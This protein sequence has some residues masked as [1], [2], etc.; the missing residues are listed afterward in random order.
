MDAPYNPS[1][2]VRIAA[3][4]TIVAL[5]IAMLMF[6]REIIIPFTL[7]VFLTF[8]LLPI[9]NWL[10]AKKI[11]HAI[12]IL[13]SIF[14]AGIVLAGLI[15][16]FYAQIIS[17]S[18]DLPELKEQFIIKMNRI[19]EYIFHEFNIS[20]RSQE[21]W[22]MEK[23]KRTTGNSEQIIVSLFSYTGTFLANLALIPVYAFFL[24]YFKEKYKMFIIMISPSAEQK[25]VLGIMRQVSKV[26]QKYLKG[27]LIDVAILSVLN[28]TG[29]LILGIEHAILFGVLAS[30][31][32]IIPYIGVLI[33]SLLP[34][35]MALLTKD[36]MG[37]AIG[38]AG[39]CI[40]VQFIDNNIINPYVVGSSVSI[41]PLSATLALVAGALIWGIAGMILSIPVMGVIKVI[42]DNVPTLKPY[43]FLIGEERDYEH[44]DH[45]SERFIKSMRKEKVA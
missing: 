6:A 31:L 28:S 42:C 17:F 13:I 32:N 3:R 44:K 12:S 2:S 10:T 27:I 38:A 26:S 5:V 11:P 29:F 22:L 18:E 8:L 15:Y 35:A 7:S 36:S 45:Y 40:V 21:Q 1:L 24:T 4:F 19:Q 30:L 14:I 41:N 23:A 37:Y 39:V 9:S 43:G 34:V 33:G 25:N 16:F 20:K